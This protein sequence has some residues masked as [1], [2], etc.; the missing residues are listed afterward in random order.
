MA[1]AAHS[2]MKW[3]LRQSAP[4]PPTP[5]PPAAMGTPSHAMLKLRR[6]GVGRIERVEVE[7]GGRVGIRRPAHE[8]IEPPLQQTAGE[9]DPP[10]AVGADQADVGPKA[11]HLEI[12]AAA[13][14]RPAQSEDVT[15]PQ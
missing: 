5:L 2:S 8:P 4:S 10:P 3:R 13:R 6:R 12:A 1:W 7:V 15:A 9:H 11:H 14:M